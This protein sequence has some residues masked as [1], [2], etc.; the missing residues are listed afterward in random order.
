MQMKKALG[1]RNIAVHHY[2]ESDWEIVH[3]IARHHLDDFTEFAK[4]TA[5]RLAG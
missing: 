4:V 5:S 1:F 2:G 3:T